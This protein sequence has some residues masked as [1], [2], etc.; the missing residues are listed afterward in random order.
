MSQV[1]PKPPFVPSNRYR[2]SGRFDGGDFLFSNN[3]AIMGRSPHGRTNVR[4]M[5]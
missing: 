2:N 3:S 5:R 4:L 1:D